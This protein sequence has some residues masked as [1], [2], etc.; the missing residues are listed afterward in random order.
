MTGPIRTLILGG[1][2]IG[3]MTSQVA[4]A[5]PSRVDPLVSLSALG[6]AQSRAAVCAA[7]AAAVA[8]AATAQ[9]GQT[10][11]CVL[12]VGAAQAAPPVGQGPM[13]APRPARS[14]SSLALIGGLVAILAGAAFLLLDDDDGDGDLQPISP[15]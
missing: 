8:S 15:A 14:I 1:A 2:A 11:G 4:V 10:G 5:A 9:P 7:G 3:L 6:T 13:L 12:P